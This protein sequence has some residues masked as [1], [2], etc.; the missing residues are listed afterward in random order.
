[1]MNAAGRM[2]RFVVTAGPDATV[3][4]VAR[5]LTRRRIKRAPIVRDGKRV[6]S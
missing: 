5:M 3:G 6:A 2:T 4:E 1:M